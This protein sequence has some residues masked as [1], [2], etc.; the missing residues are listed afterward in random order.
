MMLL[1]K[2]LIEAS[3]EAVVLICAWVSQ[4]EII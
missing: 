1:S 2:V 4:R 3:I